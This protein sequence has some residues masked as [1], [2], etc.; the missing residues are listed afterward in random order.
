MSTGV[1]DQRTI[2]KPP[3]AVSLTRAMLWNWWI[4]LLSLLV[5]V[6]IG[7]GAA[8]LRSPQYTA[9]SKLSIGGINISAPGALSGY[10]TATEALAAGYSRTVNALAVARPVSAK[11]GISVKDVQSHVSGTPIKESPVFRIKATSPDPDQAVELANASGRALIR[12]AAALNRANPD[13]PRLLANYR[14]AVLEGKR[15]KQ[16][17]RQAEAEP[18]SASSAE[19]GVR[20]ARTAVEAADLRVGAIGDAYTLSVQSQVAT[21]LIQVISPATEAA[22]DRR[23]TFVIYAV[24]GFVVGLLAGAG[25]AFWRES[26]GAQLEI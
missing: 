7:V 13:T 21:R 12:Y 10:A 20:A 2:A 6:A 14:E 24:I 25:L 11:T 1:N 8:L 22:S 23:S 19:A 17:L 9:T 16:Q 4:V 18:R 26:Y 5:F 15:A 3:P